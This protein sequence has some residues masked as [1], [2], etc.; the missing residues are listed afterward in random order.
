M[1]VH[2]GSNMAPGSI[3]VELGVPSF[4]MQVFNGDLIIRILT[5]KIFSDY[6]ALPSAEKW[7]IVGKV[8]IVGLLTLGVCAAAV[9][10]NPLFVWAI[11]LCLLTTMGVS[12][13]LMTAPPVPI[14]K[15]Q[16][17][18]VVDPK[19]GRGYTLGRQ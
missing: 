4:V 13:G 2:P 5:L 12:F 1:S 3:R 8:A 17:Q 19:L 15:P 16:P 10:M 7:C 18:V 9:V 6:A 11:P 14:I